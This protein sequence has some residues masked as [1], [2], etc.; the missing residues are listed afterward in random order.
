MSAFLTY[1]ERL[2]LSTKL[3][4][5]LGSMFSLVVLMGV[6]SIYSVRLQN[7]EIQRLYEL[8]LKG[9]S[10]LKNAEVH[11]ME[12]GR[13]L[14]QVLLAPDI[15]SRLEA[16]NDLNKART[17]LRHALVESSARFLMP[18]GQ[19]MVSDLQDMLAAYLR[20]VDHVLAL[21]E[22]D[23]YFRN[24]ALARFLVSAENVQVFKA[25]DQLMLNLV[26]RKEKKAQQA[27]EN[28]A[29]FSEQIERWTIGLLLVGV[30]GGLGSGLLLGASVRRPS[31]RLRQGIEK[32][33]QGQLDIVVGDT[34]FKNEV[35]AMARSLT[36]LQTGARHAEALR[37]VKTN[38]LELAAK[39]QAIQ[40]VQ[41][42]ACTLMAHLTPLSGAQVSLLYVL[43]IDTSK[44][45]V[46]GSW[47][48][49]D[50]SALT[51]AFARGEGLPGQCACDARPILIDAA[52]GTHLRVHSGLLDTAPQWVRLLPVCSSHGQVLA[53]MELAGI[54][55]LLERQDML[56]TATLPLVALNLEILARNQLSEKLLRQTTEQAE[57]LRNQRDEIQSA[58]EQ[59][60]EATRAKS[61]FLANMSHEI[62]TPMN[63]VIGL[64]HLALKTDLQPRQRDY[65]QKIHGSGTAL[66]GIINE[67]LDFSKIEAGKMSL[68]LAPFL[69]DDV[70]DGLATLV[71]H[72][73]TEKELEFLIRV[74]PGTPNSLLGDATRLRQIL[75]NLVGNAIKFT[76]AGQVKVDIA[77]SQRQAEQVELTVAIEDTGVGMTPAQCAQ[78]FQAFRQVDSST[79]RRFGGTGLGL[80][81]SKRFVEMMGGNITVTSQPGMGST[82]SFTAWLGVSDTLSP[83]LE[84]ASLNRGLRVLVVDDN[85][86]ARQI[87]TE[88][89]EELGLRADHAS[90]GRECL[91][92]LQQA[93]THDPYGVVVMDW[94]M[95]GLDGLQ[96]TRCVTQEV[97]L[98]H[99]PLVV[100]VT[101]FGADEVRSAGLSAGASAFLDKPVSQSR[102]WDTLADITRPKPQWQPPAKPPAPGATTL[103]GLRV[104]LVEDNDINQ[105][106]ARELMES[107]GVQVTLA[108]HGQQA[109]EML[110]RAP[111]PLPWS[112]VLM[113]L[114]MPVMDGHQATQKLRQQARFKY[115]PIIALTA[116]ASPEEGA[117]CLAE[118]MNQ[119][120]T[121]PIDPDAL[122]ECLAQWGLPQ[123]S[124]QPLVIE[125]INVTQGLRF[126]AGNRTLYNSLLAKFL[127]SMGEVPAQMR[128][129]LANN[130]LQR[131]Q[132]LVHTLK[133][134][135]ANLGASQ[136]SSLSDHLEKA[137]GRAT[138][139]SELDAH[140]HLLEQHLAVLTTRVQQALPPPASTEAQGAGNVDLAPLASV[141]QS[142]AALLSAS[143]IEAGFLLHQHE[144]L[145]RHGLGDGFVLL[146]RHIEDFDYQAALVALIHAADAAQI[147]LN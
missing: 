145:L 116:H 20:N 12:T 78:L 100:M 130:D 17:D 104:L 65:L 67:I 85:P 51:P 101:A 35:G 109:L 3:M 80:T 143:K 42:F 112:L 93:D 122:F 49:A 89:L 16:H 9:L 46:Q 142:L 14:R 87:L 61:E 136:C 73:A 72:R 34:D 132:R 58:R 27:A 25:T 110:Q 99:R 2:K 141:C 120:L 8:E 128:E 70:L 82:F 19:K 114:Q 39:V 94:H 33:A 102:L 55:P 96:T 75:I 95:P 52:A 5:G 119:H 26:R 131:A 113:D 6:Q 77:V 79:T 127:A 50:P 60:E 129:A 123:L 45:H 4:L 126:C 38:S 121:K 13:A 69:L 139:Q 137:L 115:L 111:D 56:L 53:V 86:A 29:V 15:D 88:Q 124:E 66:L 81:I 63:A 98:Q 76:E 43:D 108:D 90:G 18:E 97:A 24:D 22:K 71:A 133:G 11:L 59:A 21:Q 146:H 62:R 103:A 135:A 31:E 134:V 23:T 105:Q 84:R 10:A 118:G 64:S 48:V 47:G 144:A 68:E 37:W 83:P 40:D 107:M 28:A 91:A 125:G 41:E 32:L 74:A 44:Y 30:A 147:N 92:A 140:L 7:A 36:V 138:P 117:R 1:F 106:I 57:T 54:E